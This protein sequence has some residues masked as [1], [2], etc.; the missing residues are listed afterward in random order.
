[1]PLVRFLLLFL[2]NV[3]A[4]IK[5]VYI[6]IPFLYHRPSSATTDISNTRTFFTS[7]LFGNSS[8][9]KLHC[10]LLTIFFLLFYAAVFRCDNKSYIHIFS[11]HNIFSMR[12]NLYIFM[13][14]WY[15]YAYTSCA[16]TGG[17]NVFLTL[18]NDNDY[19]FSFDYYYG[20]AVVIT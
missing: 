19:R 14:G 4:T 7:F 1:M 6:Y 11:T 8:Q 3:I 20:F 2:C 12:L 13:G 10:V 5:T 17:V 18:R 16:I 15:M 9:A